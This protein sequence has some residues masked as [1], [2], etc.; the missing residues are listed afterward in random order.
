MGILDK[1]M[2]LFTSKKKECNILIVGL[3]NSGKSSIINYFK[4]ND[5]KSH[6]IIPTVGFNVEKF[7][8]K[9]I[10]FTT[11]DMSGQGRY[12]NLWEHYYKETD[13]II[14]VVDSTDRVRMIVAKE[15]LFSLLGHAD[16][17]NR[18]IP[19]LFFANKTDIKA[20]LSS[21]KICQEL[22][23]DKIKN[24]KWTIIESSALNGHGLNEGIDW[25]SQELKLK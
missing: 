24:T 16:I 25:L 23:L 3:D 2:S 12:R 4:P 19:I 7:S 15:E 5:S 17:I 10:N 13:A 22:D 11:F 21:Q 14:F 6:I 9:T 18:N 20:A 1:L 8:A